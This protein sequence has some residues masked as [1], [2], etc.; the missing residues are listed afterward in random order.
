ALPEPLRSLVVE[1]AK[2]IG[3]DESFVALPGLAAAAGAIGATRVLRLKRDWREPCVLWCVVV[4]PSGATKSQG[5]KLVLA[6][7]W[8]RERDELKRH[9]AALR[10]FDAL[11][12]EHEREVAAW[13]KSKDGGPPP[14]A[15]AKPE[16]VEFTL[17]DTTVEG[18]ARALQRNPRGLLVESDELAAWF[19]SFNQYRDGADAQ[20]WM[21]MHGGGRLKVN[22]AGLALP[23]YIDRACASVSGTVQP[24]ILS[25]CLS[26]EH[27]E[28][29]LAARLLFA[30][31]PRRG[32]RWTDDEVSERTTRAWADRLTDLLDLEFALPEGDSDAPEPIDCR[33]SRDAQRRWIAFV[34]E[35]G[36]EGMERDGAELAA[37]SKLEGYA[38][39]L[40]LVLHLIE[41]PE[42]AEVSLDTL[43]HAIELVGW[44]AGE[45]ERFYRG[46]KADPKLALAEKLVA[47]IEAR[48]GEVTA[49]DL[50]KG[51][52]QYRSSDAA[53]RGLQALVD[54]G[55]GAWRVSASATNQARVFTLAAAAAHSRE[56][57]VSGESVAVARVATPENTFD[58]LTFAQDGSLL[59]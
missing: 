11:S 2:S 38:A 21:M 33:L 49:R 32:K 58:P 50:A 6:P 46:A 47:W 44:F 28:S 20:H 34:N 15:P 57:R 43:E 9:Q 12:N 13:K 22:R 17:S 35:H 8:K 27:R 4:S 39:R 41:D 14:E 19:K 5:R 59:L 7:L 48:G 23:L 51:P 36:A 10:E 24:A 52:R 18:A 16:L 29:G 45:A 37:W 31:P 42:G 56:T 1:G 53:E 25:E 55:L 30:H 26:G 40:A 3:C 54:A